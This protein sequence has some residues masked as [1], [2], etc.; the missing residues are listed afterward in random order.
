MEPKEK[1]QLGK[2]A[3]C[4]HVLKRKIGDPELST[5]TMVLQPCRGVTT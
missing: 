5:A 2:N 3:P 1:A 4:M